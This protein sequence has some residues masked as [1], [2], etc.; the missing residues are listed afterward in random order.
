[1]VSNRRAAIG[2]GV[3]IVWAAM[4]GWHVHREYFEPELTR[5]T[6]ATMSLAPG[7]NFY[8]LRMGNETVGTAT[9]RLD[10]VPDGGGFILQ[11]Q[12]NLE[13]AALGQSGGAM[14]QTRVSLSPTLS[15]ESFSFSLASD[16]GRFEARGSVSG[17]TLLTVDVDAGGSVEEVSFRLQDPPIFAAVLPIRV[18]MSGE[19]R[20]GRTFRFPVFD[21]STVSTRTVEVQVLAQD[22]L[23]VPDTVIR[24]PGSGR[25]VPSGQVAVPAW[26]ISED[27][28]GIRVE[29]WI[30]ADGR[31]L[32]SSSPMGFSMEKTEFELARQDQDD[33][34]S[35]GGGR[36]AGADVVLNTAIES[37]V[38]LGRVETHDE[39]RFLLSGV[40]LEGFDLDGGRQEL[41]GDTLIVRRESWSELSPEYDLPYPRMD[42]REALQ[43]EPLIQSG[44]ERIIAE[45]R[46]AVSWRSRGGNDP[47]ASAQR[48]NVH[49]HRLIR[50]EMAFAIPSALQ[51]LET[52]R[53]DCNE[54]TVLY[55]ALAR[56]L[57]LPARTAVGL[58][59]M[60]GAFF[61]HSWP[62]VWLGEWVA[63]DPTLGQSPASAAHIR[64]R[65]GGLAQQVEIARLIGS[66]RI[67]V[68]DELPRATEER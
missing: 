27:Y 48:L 1:M 14:T 25:W 42:L 61:Y 60:E 53:G 41:R 58:V 49:V 10:T 35:R 47:K 23:M 50:K 52:R 6:R 28:G 65:V 19:L 11:D 59:Y 2:V 13:L 4:V 66:L 43:P 68:L 56:S 46:E 15:M 31:V 30:D 5:L 12:M 45:A 22:T 34:R 17:D 36:G 32:R 26:Q 16:A 39:L 21:P 40:D 24:E 57:G 3:L 20:P 7:T 51:V 62:E 18:A 38:D 54:H 37:N 29:S 33:T 44:N 9:S 64:F 67:R 8:A 55:V 63:M